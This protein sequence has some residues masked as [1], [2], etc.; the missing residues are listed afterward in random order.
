LIELDAAGIQLHQFT[1]RFDIPEAD[2]LVPTAGDEGAAIRRKRHGIDRTG[3]PLDSSSTPRILISCSD[4]ML[5]LSG[6]R[7]ALCPPSGGS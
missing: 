5:E 6:S 4:K 1:A 7:V 3:M 2:S